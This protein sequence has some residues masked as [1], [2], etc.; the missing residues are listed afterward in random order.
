MKIGAVIPV[1]NEEIRIGSVLSRFRP[2]LVDEVVVV[3]DGSTDRTPEV[4]RRFPVTALRHP[5]RLGVGTAIRDGLKHL[6]SRGFD[7]AVVMAGNG[8]D[9]PGE[10]PRVVAPIILGEAAYVQGSRFLNGGS[11]KNLPWARFA[12]I[13]GYT[14]LWSL[15]VGRKLTDVTNGFRAYRLELLKDPRIRLD[16]DWLDKYELEYYLHYKA[17]SLGLKFREVAVSRN[18]PSR[19]SYSKIRPILDWWGIIKPLFLL[20]LGL[21]S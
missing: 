8:K 21:R 11:F 18:Y 14:S 17:L 15:L 4:L 6:A 20:R 1:Y 10:I 19:T 7:A 5:T 9:D 16:Q 13:K 3:D 2:D 12:M